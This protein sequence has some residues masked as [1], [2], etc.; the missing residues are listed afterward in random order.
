MKTKN[1]GTKRRPLKSITNGL[2]QEKEDGVNILSSQRGNFILMKALDIISK[3]SNILRNG[4]LKLQ[5]VKVI[6]PW[7]KTEA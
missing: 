4:E 6:N 1:F 2:S 3:D 5:N 7:H